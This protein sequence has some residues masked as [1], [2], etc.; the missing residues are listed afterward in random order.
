[1]EK[2]CILNNKFE[3]KKYIE[4]GFKCRASFNDEHHLTPSS[5]GGQTISS[6]LLKIDAYRHDAIHLLFGNKTINEIIDLFNLIMSEFGKE[7]IP[8][9]LY[10]HDCNRYNA[11]ILLFGNK[12]IVEV[13][14]IL[15]RTRDIKLTKKI[16]F[17]L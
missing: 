6:N 10:M 9:N 4:H 17:I 13:I 11:S 7:I 5:R 14:K 3:R 2:D 15:E 12:T 16:N 1:M 8:A